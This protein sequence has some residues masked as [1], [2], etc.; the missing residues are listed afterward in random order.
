MRITRKLSFFLIPFV[1]I[2]TLTACKPTE[3]EL[4]F[5]NVICTADKYQH[6]YE[7]FCG[8]A[9]FE[10]TP[11]SD[12]E[13][14]QLKTD[15]TNAIDSVIV[16]GSPLWERALENFTNSMN[17]SEPQDKYYFDCKYNIDKCKIKMKSNDGSTAV[18]DVTL[19]SELKQVIREEDGTYSASILTSEWDYTITLQNEDGQWKLYDSEN[20]TGGL[21]SDLEDF[22]T[23]NTFDEAYNAF[24]VAE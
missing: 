14:E 6:V 13:I 10:G 1:F 5:L 21:K 18:T 24:A 15:Y 3:E 11:L 2:I 22:G 19:F 12:T 7:E 8:T 4:T 17:H 9:K 20:T 16:S 23:F